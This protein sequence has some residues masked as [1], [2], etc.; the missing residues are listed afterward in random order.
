[1]IRVISRGLLNVVFT[2]VVAIGIAGV[3][4]VHAVCENVDAS[5][6]TEGDFITSHTGCSTYTALAVTNGNYTQYYYDCSVCESG[7]TL[8]A[9]SLRNLLAECSAS[10]YYGF[11]QPTGSVIQPPACVD[12]S[13]CSSNA[14]CATIFGSSQYYCT[15]ANCCAY[16]ETGNCGV[17]EYLYTTY[18]SGGEE[19][20]DSSGGCQLCT[21]LS[22][23]DDVYYLDNMGADGTGIN[24]AVRSAT[25]SDGGQNYDT[26]CYI[27]EGTY[28]DKTGEF[29]M[30]KDCYYE[31]R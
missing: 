15:S 12:G 16:R 7:Y 19:T 27:P 25:T 29:T 11:C 4:D 10:R 14:D 21:S 6:A 23:G 3:R 18:I 26:S 22:M 17:G 31:Y 5:G 28:Y 8:T 9:G 30:D 20:Y 1:M 13:H 2:F 24:L